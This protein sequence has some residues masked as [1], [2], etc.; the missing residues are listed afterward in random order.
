MGWLLFFI[1][2]AIGGLPAFFM[3]K[4]KI[5]GEWYFV[6]GL[7]FAGFQALIKTSFEVQ[8]PNSNLPNPFLP[9]I[10]AWFL[11]ELFLFFSF[12]VPSFL[13]T[14]INLKHSKKQRFYSQAKV[15]TRRSSRP[16]YCGRLT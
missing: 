3:Q 16:A 1:A 4:T 10:F 2:I 14:N 8:A 15:L 7:V 9:S 11:T 6:L 5:A 13:K 12:L